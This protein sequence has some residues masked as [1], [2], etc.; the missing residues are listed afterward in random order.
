MDREASLTPVRPSSWASSWRA[1]A[2]GAALGLAACSGAGPDDARGE[3][4]ADTPAADGTATGGAPTGPGRLDSAAAL[5]AVEPPDTH[6]VELPTPSG[7][8]DEAPVA[9]VGG[10]ASLTGTLTIDGTPAA[11]ATLRLERW[12]GDRSGRI[13]L[14]VGADGRFVLEDLPGGRWVVRAWREPLHAL[15]T[16]VSRFVSEG[17]A[18][19]L[20]LGLEVVLRGELV[21]EV[22]TEGPV[23]T[24]EVVELVVA[25]SVLRQG[26]PRPL[27]GVTL[28]LG[29]F[30]GWELVEGISATTDAT[31]RA[32][33]RAR[34]VAGGTADADVHAVG[35][36]RTVAL[37]TCGSEVP[38]ADDGDPS[39]EGDEPTNGA[40]GTPS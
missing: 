37:P 32:T 4:S 35:V 5:L 16:A 13:D 9:V 20:D 29:S 8:V 23:E 24:G 28:E 11:G 15:P 31:G 19:E 39:D 22:L 21:L 2:L 27:G 30:D 26:S 10:E 36:V 25:A 17:E 3:P 33:W 14:V 38:A 7:A 34:C 18:V 40:D 6:D 1:V 12:V